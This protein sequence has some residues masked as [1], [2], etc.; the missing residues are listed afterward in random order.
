MRFRYA[1]FLVIA[2]LKEMRKQTWPQKKLLGKREF[3]QQ[4]GLA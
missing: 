2:I 3:E 4:N 1:G